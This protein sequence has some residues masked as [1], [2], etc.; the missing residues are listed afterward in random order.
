ML[1]EFAP[2]LKFP[3]Q[4]MKRKPNTIRDLAKSMDA[5]LGLPVEIN[6]EWKLPANW[7]LGPRTADDLITLHERLCRMIPD[8]FEFVLSFEDGEVYVVLEYQDGP[9]A[10]S[11]GPLPVRTDRHFIVNLS[12]VDWDALRGNAIDVMQSIES[13]VSGP[14][15]DWFKEHIANGGR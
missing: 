15:P 6:R 5:D 4:K 13:P 2:H 14:V 1:G 3:H 7:N 12:Q 11:C 8:D 10:G 9:M